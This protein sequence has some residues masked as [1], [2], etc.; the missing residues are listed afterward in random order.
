MDWATM[1]QYFTMDVLTDVA[2]SRPF[3]YLREN[4]DL[5]GYIKT[6]RNYMP[7]LEMQANIPLVNTMMNNKLIK[8]WL[9]P[10]ASDTFG[11]GKM[12]GLDIPASI[13]DSY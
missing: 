1:S 4:A 8:K 3:G 11:M 2:F 13:K 9:A 6:V 5:F 7:V 10:T 12:M